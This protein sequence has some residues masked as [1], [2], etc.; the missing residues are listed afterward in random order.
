MIGSDLRHILGF[1]I[2]ALRKRHG[3]DSRL[4]F[5]MAWGRKRNSRPSLSADF[6]PLWFNRTRPWRGSGTELL[7]SQLLTSQLLLDEYPPIAYRMLVFKR[8][9]GNL[10]TF[11]A[12]CQY[13][14]LCRHTACKIA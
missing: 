2:T 9:N 7:T 5:M 6:G 13:S 8:S 3:E 1:F 10:E 12:D 4:G 11:C 14:G